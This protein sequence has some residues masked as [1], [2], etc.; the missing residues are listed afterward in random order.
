MRTTKRQLKL[1][2][3]FCDRDPHFRTVIVETTRCKCP[4]CSD[5]LVFARRIPIIDQEAPATSLVH[6]PLSGRIVRGNSVG[7]KK[8]SGQTQGSH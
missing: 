2:C 7:F 1:M 6:P 5:R 4:H 3:P 8:T